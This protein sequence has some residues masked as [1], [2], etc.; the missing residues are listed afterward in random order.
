VVAKRLLDAETFADRIAQAAFDG[1]GASDH[2][3]SGAIAADAGGR[4]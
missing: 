1:G 2:V 4:R 3:G